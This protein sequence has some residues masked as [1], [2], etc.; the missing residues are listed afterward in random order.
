MLCCFYLETISET[1]H[2]LATSSAVSGLSGGSLRTDDRTFGRA[3][4]PGTLSVAADALS[5][6]RALLGLDIDIAMQTVRVEISDNPSSLGGIKCEGMANTYSQV[7][8]GK[9]GI[10]CNG[11]DSMFLLIY[12]LFPNGT[13][14]DNAQPVQTIPYYATVA[15]DQDC[16]FYMTTTGTGKDPPAAA[17]SPDGRHIVASTDQEVH[18][19]PVLP[20][21][22]IHPLSVAFPQILAGHQ[23]RVVS[24]DWSSDGRYLVS[25]ASDGIIKIWSVPADY[26]SGG[27]S[28]F[29]TDTVMPVVPGLTCRATWSPSSRRVAA[30]CLRSPVRL[31]KVL[32]NGT[33]D[34]SSLQELPES[35]S[36]GTAASWSPDG[37]FLAAGD[38]NGKVRLWSMSSS[39]ALEAPVEVFDFGAG[40]WVLSTA[41]SPDSRSLA[42]GGNSKS[43]HL[44]VWRILPGGTADPK[45]KQ[46]SFTGHT[47]SIRFVGWSPLGTELM[48][49]CTDLTVRIWDARLPGEPGRTGQVDKEILDQIL[50]VGGIVRDVAY[51]PNGRSLATGGSV[52]GDISVWVVTQT[53]KYRKVDQ[54]SKQILTGHTDSV[55]SVVWSPSGLH[56]ASASHDLTIRLWRHIHDGMIDPMPLQ[57]VQTCHT[58][59]IQSMSWSPGGTLLASGSLDNSVEVWAVEEFSNGTI[60]IRGDNPQVLEHLTKVDSVAFSPSGRH[61]A[62][63]CRDGYVWVWPLAAGGTEIDIGSVQVLKGHTTWAYSVSWSPDGKHLASGSMDKTIRVW[64]VSLVD[65]KVGSPQ[66]LAAQ[67]QVWATAWSP[68]GDQ[69]AIA[70][71]GTKVYVWTRH[72]LPDVGDGI[73]PS[74]ASSTISGQSHVVTTL[75]WDPAG[76]GWLASAN[77]NGTVKLQRLLSVDDTRGLLHSTW[78]S[79]NW[80][81]SNEEVAAHGIPPE[82]LSFPETPLQLI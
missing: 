18:L 25:S 77:Y 51:S 45:F 14:D 49:T 64:P 38:L 50:D 55:R 37:K 54:L 35:R 5:V 33:A 46:R 78:P 32:E 22:T 79:T 23:A 76:D 80:T 9:V 74:E 47:R 31:W 15:K 63:G 61:L 39:E 62:S 36:D 21:G 34:L 24:L 10:P 1:Y 71:S 59:L 44:V 28:P 8:Q 70:G 11:V 68:S 82:I 60:G 30:D 3:A 52:T 67:D 17:Y 40:N 43:R 56:L 57:V 58:D 26:R 48:T 2:C 13:V 75:S 19:W 72:Q 42:V 29:C 6:A 7:E 4:G 81:L 16:G 73:F 27:L 20:D 69:L 66:V 65:G 53:S 41:F 12:S